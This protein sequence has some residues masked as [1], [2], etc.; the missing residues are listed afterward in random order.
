MAGDLDPAIIIIILN[1]LALLHSYYKFDTT[2]TPTAIQIIIIKFMITYKYKVC[3]YLYYIINITI[4]H[5]LPI[6]KFLCKVCTNKQFYISSWYFFYR[7]VAP[8]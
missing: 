7:S 8:F 3:M 4:A 5:F 1:T 2:S 6:M